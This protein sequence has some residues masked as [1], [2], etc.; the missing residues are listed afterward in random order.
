MGDLSKVED[1]ESNPLAWKKPD[2][3]KARAKKLSEED[4]PSAPPQ[5]SW[6]SPS[7]ISSPKRVVIPEWK[8][9]LSA[10]EEEENPLAWKKP[11]WAKTRVLRKTTGE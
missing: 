7:V 10:G 5:E 9:D 8:P 2:W 6:T 4:A 3:A 1:E 11:D